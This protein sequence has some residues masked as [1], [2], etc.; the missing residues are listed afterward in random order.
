[1]SSCRHSRRRS[2]RFG[3]ETF[4]EV[5]PLGQTT[6]DPLEQLKFIRETIESAGSFTAVPGKGM[7]LIGVSALVIAALTARLQPTI[8]TFWVLLW[9]AEALL[10]FV[11]ALFFM[12]RKA[13]RAGQSLMSG[14]AKKFALSFAPPMLVGTLVTLILFRANV[15]PAIPAMWLM[16]YGTAVIT[17]GAFSVRIVP[18]MGA[19]FLGLGA[20]AAFTPAA[21]ANIYMATG[22][23]GLHIVFGAIV[24][25]KHGG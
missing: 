9:L 6:S 8:S 10:A 7:V 1:M 22:F 2:R 5:P 25:R 12:A 23:G 18:V 15:A 13:E 14:P 17:G 3:R 4:G 21:W 19:C 11:L 20:V 16:L 24:A